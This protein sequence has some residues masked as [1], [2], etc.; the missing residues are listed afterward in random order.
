M[1]IYYSI[2]V[3]PLRASAK[4]EGTKE[5]RCSFVLCFSVLAS[6]FLL[7]GSCFSVLASRFSGSAV[8]RFKAA[9]NTKERRNEG[10]KTF[11]LFSGSRFCRDAISCVVTR[12][13]VQRFY[14]SL[15][16][17]HDLTSQDRQAIAHQAGY[18]C[19]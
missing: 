10:T 12:F 15:R 11:F 13:S 17:P 2:I 4:H 5:R 9:F 14:A 6:R 3:S 7:L 1:I 16:Q 18:K 19:L 8:Q